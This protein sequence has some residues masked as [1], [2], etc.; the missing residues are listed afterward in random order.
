[1]S[2]VRERGAR[3]WRVKSGWSPAQ[4]RVALIINVRRERNVVV[5]A[6]SNNIKML[7][8]SLVVIE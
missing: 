1:M 7:C 6:N 5:Q 8:S 4:D 2:V 3:Q